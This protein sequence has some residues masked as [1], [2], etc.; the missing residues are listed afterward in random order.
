VRPVAA[1]LGRFVA[2]GLARL[3]DGTQVPLETLED[4]FLVLG[5]R[6]ASRGDG[7]EVVDLLLDACGVALRELLVAS[8]DEL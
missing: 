2:E 4:F 6:A 1:K 7:F 8:R 5:E 3:V